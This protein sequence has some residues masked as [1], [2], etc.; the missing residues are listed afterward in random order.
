M[1]SSS[2]VC[3]LHFTSDCLRNHQN[4]KVLNHDAIPSIFESHP[5]PFERGEKPIGS[6]GSYETESKV[7]DELPQKR[8]KINDIRNLSDKEIDSMPL[9]VLRVATKQL[10]RSY[11]HIYISYQSNYQKLYY[12]AHKPEINNSETS[13]SSPVSS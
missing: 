11:N 6:I 9:D 4:C 3:S 8:R 10:M 5:N 1:F 13:Q 2:C 7:T 12:Q